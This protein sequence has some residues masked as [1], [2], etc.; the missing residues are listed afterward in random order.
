MMQRGWGQQMVAKQVRLMTVRGPGQPR[1]IISEGAYLVG[2]LTKYLTKA[3]GLPSAGKKKCFSATRGSKVGTIRF[4]WVPWERPGS[5]LWAMG[6]DAFRLLHGRLPWFSDMMAV[7]ALG[8]QVSH[9]DEIDFLWD[10]GFASFN[11]S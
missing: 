1:R 5:Y 7:I 9:W 8:V 11:S 10:F 4:K 2:Y 6:Y 3:I